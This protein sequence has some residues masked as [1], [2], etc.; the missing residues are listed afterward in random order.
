M[1]IGVKYAF[2]FFRIPFHIFRGLLNISLVQI[3]NVLQY[4]RDNAEYQ[5]VFY[6]KGKKR[7]FKTSFLQ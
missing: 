3:S 4:V 2:I 5:N 1:N 7:E 6:R